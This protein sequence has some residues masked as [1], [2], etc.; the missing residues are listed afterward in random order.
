MPQTDTAPNE[1]I[2]MQANGDTGS[3][4]LRPWRD[5]TRLAFAPV[6]FH[7]VCLA[8]DKG[9][10]RAVEKAGREGTTAQALAQQLGLSVYA[11]TVLLDGCAAAGVFN[12]HDARYRLTRTGWLI[13]HEPMTRANMDFSRDVCD[14]AMAHLDE[15]IATGQP[16][17]LK[18]LVDAPTVYEG[19]TRLPPKAL[20]SWLKFDHYYSDLVFD[21]A[22]ALV[23]TKRPKRLLDVGGNTGKFALKAA[24]HSEVTILDHPGQIALAL[25]NAQKAGL[26]QRVSGSAMNLLDHSRAFP[27]GFDAVWMSQFLC[28]FGLADVEQLL[29]RA[30]AALAPGGRIW[31]NETFI[32]RQPNDVARDAV[33]ATSLYFTAVAN[34]QSCMYRLTD[35][36]PIFDR[37]GL[38]VAAEYEL[39]PYHQLIE[40]EAI[41]R[42]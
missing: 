41:A 4:R 35:F 11:A 24:K 26:E 2:P 1:A 15:A 25:E 28:C 39:P 34:G 5:A 37:L 29:R 32:D 7:A 17:G 18:E 36:L 30:R 40:L 33:M 42:S 10:I 23:A 20:E 31:V 6:L 21:P 16:S 27:T 13:E 14:R 8:R 3:L 38:R 9:I 12:E 19:L 22:L